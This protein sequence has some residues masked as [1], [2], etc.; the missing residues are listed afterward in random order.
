M[1]PVEFIREVETRYPVTEAHAAGLQVWPFLRQLYFSQHTWKTYGGLRSQ[2]VDRRRELRRVL[3]LCHGAPE[4]F[5][6]H[7]FVVFSSCWRRRSLGGRLVDK[8]ADWFCQE[9]GRDNV[10]MIENPM[11]PGGVDFMPGRYPDRHIVS[12]DLFNLATMLGGRTVAIENGASLDQINRDYG[13]NVDYRWAVS[14]FMRV[15]RFARVCLRRWHPRLVL[16][17]GYYGLVNQAVIHAAH[18]ERLDTAEFQHGMTTASHEAYRLFCP[19]EHECFPRYFLSYGDYVKDVFR[20]EFSFLNYDRVLPVGDGYIEYIR[21]VYEDEYGIR[22]ILRS[23]DKSVT[24]TSQP[25]VH[26]KLAAFVAKAAS[27]DPRIVYLFVPRPT[28]KEP[29]RIEFPANV[30]VVENIEFYKLAKYTDY[31][32][33]VYSTCALEAPL[34]GT[35]NLLVDIDGLANAHYGSMLKDPD[36][37]RYV[38][39]PEEL[40]RLIRAWNPSARDEV[41]RRLSSLCVPDHRKA[42]RQAIETILAAGGSGRR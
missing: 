17:S 2:V 33:T 32:A 23:Y 27:L 34:L 37:T 26:S 41:S 10:L 19:M 1:M 13:L 22:G 42:V 12:Y 29:Q 21:D 28:D 20:H 16:L 25:Q 18:S 6:Q 30:R 35:P 3:N 24:V 31:H 15:T 39:E 40:V 8:N 7:P 38:S 4:W 5:R 14:A 11:K 36:V 9:F